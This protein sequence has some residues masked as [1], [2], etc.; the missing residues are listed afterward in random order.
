M[1]PTGT[2][3]RVLMAAGGASNTGPTALRAVRKKKS[4]SGGQ[5]LSL[6]RGTIDFVVK[7]FYGGKLWSKTHQKTQ[8]HGILDS[9]SR[10]R[11]RMDHLVLSPEVEDP[12]ISYKMPRTTHNNPSG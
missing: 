7:R 12:D 8:Y 5:H 6:T 11:P 10:K 4:T 9:T 3:A 1:V 2:L